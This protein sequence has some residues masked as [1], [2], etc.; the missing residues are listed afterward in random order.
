MSDSLI[1]NTSGDDKISINQ[2]CISSFRLQNTNVN[3][4]DKPVNIGTNMELNENNDM[5]HNEKPDDILDDVLDDVPNEESDEESDESLQSSSFNY[6]N[7]MYNCP[8]IG[9]CGNMTN[10]SQYCCK[11]YCPRE[12][13]QNDDDNELEHQPNYKKVK[14]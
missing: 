5:K 13:E 11:Y 1:S 2:E 6:Y 12:E 14:Y 8:C 4:E 3:N 9:G 7:T 10:G